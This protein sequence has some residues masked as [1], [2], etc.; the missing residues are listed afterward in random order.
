MESW[1]AFPDYERVY[2]LDP[3]RQRVVDAVRASMSIPFFYEPT[4]LESRDGT[5]STLVDGGLLSNFPVDLLDRRDGRPP[6]WPTFGIKLL[7]RLPVD[8]AK[9]L[10]IAG[11]LK[12]GPIALAADLA[13]TA[14]VG[15]DQAHLAKPWVQVRTMQVDTAGVSPVDF[16]LGRDQA[17]G[18][19]AA[20]EAAASSF[21]EEWDWEEYL[22]RFRSG[23]APRRAPSSRRQRP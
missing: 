6:R 9:V 17:A 7:P 8:A 18:L 16:G 22:R 4:S 23:P 19:F 10:P 20:G 13:M 21:L 15:R 5:T 3:T 14:V 12:H 2:G 11:L 1:C